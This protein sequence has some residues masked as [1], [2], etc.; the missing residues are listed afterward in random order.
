VNEYAVIIEK[1]AY[2][3]LTKIL[4]VRIPEGLTYNNGDIIR[5]ELP[6]TY[7]DDNQNLQSQVIVKEFEGIIPETV[8]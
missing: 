8:Y 7:L 5:L 4:S 1:V 2:D 3:D 6:V